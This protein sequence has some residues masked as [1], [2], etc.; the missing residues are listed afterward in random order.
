[1]T[2]SGRERTVGDVAPGKAQPRRIA[3]DVAHKFSS[4]RLRICNV[5]VGALR[6]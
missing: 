3:A 6:T 1:M 2:A 4:D 5:L